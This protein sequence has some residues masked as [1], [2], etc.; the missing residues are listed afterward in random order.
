MKKN[1]LFTLTSLLLI[2]LV[3]F[4][5]YASGI[6]IDEYI[7]QSKEEV[8]IID[9]LTKFQEAK[10][11]F[12]SPKYLSCLDENGRFMFGGHLMVSKKELSAL[13][14]DF[15]KRLREN[16]AHVKPMCRENLNGNFF[17]GSFFNP[18]ISI[19]NNSAKV[20]LTFQTPIVRW[21]TLLFLML[22][23]ENGVWLITQYE[24]D[25]G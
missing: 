9:L 25:M 24:W 2:S 17:N 21:R 8:E 12:D 10:Q 3:F 20:T 14:P 11:K 18:L 22:I 13:L 19:D 4:F 16:D 1:L 5:A 15:W 7:P 6:P 23:K